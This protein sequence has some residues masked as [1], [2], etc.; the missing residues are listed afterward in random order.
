MTLGREGTGVK[1]KGGS[2]CCLWSRC[3]EFSPFLDDF[4]E[5]RLSSSFRN[6]LL[7][8]N[9]LNNQLC[10]TETCG[11]ES[12]PHSET[13]TY[14][15]RKFQ[16]G[17][18]LLRLYV[19]KAGSLYNY[20]MVIYVAQILNGKKRYLTENEILK[21]SSIMDFYSFVIIPFI[22]L[23]GKHSAV[24]GLLHLYTI[25]SNWKW[26]IFVLYHLG[27]PCSPHSLY[28]PNGAWN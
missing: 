5:C 15:T 24:S 10:L 25:L 17:C 8:W 6:C 20:R 14:N 9:V 21:P 12:L 28:V 2:P 22:F 4:F 19:N 1:L 26:N 7:T 27:W 23:V 11:E 18:S 16:D 13:S 3:A